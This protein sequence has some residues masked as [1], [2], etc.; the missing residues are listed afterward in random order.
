M[1]LFER[2]RRKRWTGGRALVPLDPDLCPA[3]GQPT[4][5]ETTVEMALVRHGGYGADR[6]TTRRHCPCGW[7]LLA[8]TVETNPRARA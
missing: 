4:D 2:Q 1:S 3:C 8:V 5:T 7:S 6:S